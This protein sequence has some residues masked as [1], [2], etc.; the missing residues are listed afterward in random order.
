MSEVAGSL[1]SLS[2]NDEGSSDGIIYL[3]F[4]CTKANANE[5]RL[6]PAGSESPAHVAHNIGMTE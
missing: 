4:R 1:E 6:A 3:M 5:E 2:V